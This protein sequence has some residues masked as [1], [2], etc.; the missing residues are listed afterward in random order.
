MATF[1]DISQGSANASQGSLDWFFNP[2]NLYVVEPITSLVTNRI[3]LPLLNRTYSCLGGVVVKVTGMVN[4]VAA[5]KIRESLKDPFST[6]SLLGIARYVKNVSMEWG[7]R[8][9][10]TYPGLHYLDTCS[11]I[12]ARYTYIFATDATDLLLAPTN[13][14]ILAEKILTAA[15]GVQVSALADA[16][17]VKPGVKHRKHEQPRSLLLEQW[18]IDRPELLGKPVIEPTFQVGKW[19]ATSALSTL[20]Q[21]AYALIAAREQEVRQKIVSEAA[22]RVCKWG[23]ASTTRATIKVGIAFACHQVVV[24]SSL[25]LLTPSL[26]NMTQTASVGGSSL[27]A[28]LFM[29]SSKTTDNLHNSQRLGARYEACVGQENITHII[30]TVKTQFVGHFSEDRM[31][32]FE[33]EVADY[34]IKISFEDG[35]ALFLQTPEQGLV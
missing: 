10:S 8:S 19:S 9:P 31:K 32:E 28:C 29:K 23:I 16:E 4:A 15:E 24:G 35:G 30:N 5:D 17:G 27:A 25:L 33:N 13:L 7:S 12:G 21:N 26:S 20:R 22:Y 11:I 14:R 34:R 3:A 6:K 18:E 1:I 2:L